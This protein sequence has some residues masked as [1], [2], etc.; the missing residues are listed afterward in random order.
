MNLPLVLVLLSVAS[1]GGTAAVSLHGPLP[2]VYVAQAEPGV[3]RRSSEARQEILGH[4]S[5]PFGD[6]AEPEVA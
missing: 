4:V 5:H 1:A 6:T 3:A 2:A